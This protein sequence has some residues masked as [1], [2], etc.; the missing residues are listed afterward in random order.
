MNFPVLFL[1]TG[2]FAGIMREHNFSVKCS[3]LLL[4]NLQTDFCCHDLLE[5]GVF[6]H[7]MI[8]LHMMLQCCLQ[9]NGELVWV[10]NFLSSG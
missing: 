5:N 6:L 10:F 1:I 4:I 7:L 2:N 3:M 9:I 8:L